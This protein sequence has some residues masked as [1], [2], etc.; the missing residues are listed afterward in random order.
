MAAEL[1]RAT[2]S[3]GLKQLPSNQAWQCHSR[4]REL[5]AR[6]GLPQWAMT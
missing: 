2:S 5:Q 6:R 1:I 4:L 3:R